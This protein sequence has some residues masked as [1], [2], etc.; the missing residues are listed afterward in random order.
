MFR[1]YIKLPKISAGL[2]GSWKRWGLRIFLS[3]LLLLLFCPAAA[4][5]KKKD[6]CFHFEIDSNVPAEN[7]PVQVQ[8]ERLYRSACRWVERNLFLIEPRKAVPCLTVYIVPRLPDDVLKP[9]GGCGP[10]VGACLERY[11]YRLYLTKWDPGYFVQ[12]ILR[13]GIEQRVTQ[14]DLIRATKKLLG[15]DAV[16]FVDY[17]KK[18]K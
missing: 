6:P 5:K 4:A 1:S 10:D 13:A 17:P 16:N 7:R 9:G 3:C 2:S 11:P 14:K 12:A 18:L 15:W 8:A